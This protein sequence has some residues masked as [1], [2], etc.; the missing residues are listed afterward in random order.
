MADWKLSPSV[1]LK[2]KTDSSAAQGFCNR[3]GL[4]R[5]RHVST[6]FLWLQDK[7]ARKEIRIEKVGTADQL[8]DL[9]TKSMS[10][11]WLVEK[12]SELSLKF[13]EG[14]SAMMKK[15]L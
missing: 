4:G 11:K 10:R 9:L 3:K 12:A 15:I 1:V 7:V 14:R 2:L 8:A 13:K 6:R 5:Q